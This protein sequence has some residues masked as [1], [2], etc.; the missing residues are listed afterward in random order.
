MKVS[1]CCSVLNQSGFLLDMIASVVNQTMKDWELIIVDDG[2]TEP[3]KKIVDKFNDPRIIY[4]RFPENKGIPHGINW[5]F[6]FAT[7][8]YVQALAADEIITPDKLEKQVSYLDAHK[9][10]EGVWGLPQFC[11]AVENQN[12]GERPLWEQYQMKAHNRSNE[13]WLRT[14]L[15]LDHVPLGS[16]SALFRRSVFDSIGYFREDLKAFSDHEWFCRFFEKHNGFVM[17]HRLALCRPNPDQVS[18]AKNAEESQKELEKV[19]ELHPLQIPATE[20]LVTVGIPCRNMAGYIGHSIKSVLDQTYQ[21]FEILILDDASTDQLDAAVAG[22]TDPRIKLFRLQERIGAHEATN[23]LAARANGLYFVPL[24][25]D[26]TLDP[27]YLEKC[28]A[29]FKG[30]PFT[31]FVASQTDF[32]DEKGNEYADK[33]HPFYAIEKASNKTQPE[34]MAR[35]WHGNVYFGVGMYKTAAYLAVG[36]RKDKYGVISDYELYLNLLQRENI[37][38]VE[39]NLTHTRITGKNMSLLDPEE[40]GKLKQRYFDAKKDYYPPRIKVILATPFYE[41]KGFSP[42]ISSMVHTVK[43]LTQMGI[44]HEFWELSGDSYV[45]RARN[46]ICT[47]FLEDPEATDLFFIDSDMQWNPEAIVNMVALPELVVGASYPTKNNWAS[48]TS[49]PTF[50]EENGKRHPMGRTLPDGSALITAEFLAAGFL[51]IK[52]A[53]LE[54]YRDHY[55]EH[56]YREPCADPS[57][58]NREYIEYF[59]S[60]RKD[61]LLYGEDMMFSKRLREM[62]MDM[63]IYTNVHMG[64]YGVK[65]WMGNYDQ[66]LRGQGKQ[67]DASVQNLT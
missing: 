48:W 61:G 21:N 18:G 62:N 43:M 67:Q 39:E 36:G 2:S 11:G 50:K 15:M 40:A 38:I 65:G 5:A 42:Y 41:L 19:R 6:K 44:Q 51:R 23:Q 30:A 24:S 16:N 46:T 58:A 1:V 14:L 7:G 59:A 64:H 25:A 22:F 47:K 55:P 34:W 56:R 49:I 45:H 3:I 33:A 9:E 31:E 29:E 66:F 35:L 10:I 37:R 26:D 28:L 8:E 20:G 57:N 17:N 54:A 12:I 53:A 60:I 13:A 27:A 4:E 63:W 52:R 32:I